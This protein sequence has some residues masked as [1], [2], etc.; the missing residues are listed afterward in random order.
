MSVSNSGNIIY[1]LLTA[2]S[3][4]TALV[5]TKIRPMKAAQSDSYPYVIYESISTP[6]LQ[7]KDGNSG[8]YKM[9]FQLSMLA[10]SLSSVQSIATAIRNALDGQNGT[11]ATYTVQAITFE[12][13]RDIFNDNSAVDGV[14]MLQQDYFITIQI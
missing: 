4:V 2:N 6:S 7:T 8:W 1:S 14:Y 10:T 13:E 11:I 12:D 9:R 5:G 3:G